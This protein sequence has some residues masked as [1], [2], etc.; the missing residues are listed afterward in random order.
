[1]VAII[2]D[3]HAHVLFHGISKV[4]L[5][6]DYET[7]LLANSNCPTLKGFEWGTTKKEVND[8]Q[9]KIAEILMI[10]QKDKRI[11]KVIMTT[12]GPSYIHDE[13]KGIFSEKSVNESFLTLYPKSFIKPSYSSFFIGY[14]N[15]IR[16]IENLPH[17]TKIFYILENP[18]LDFLP[19]EV[20]PRPYDFFNIS[21]NR[22][23]VSRTLY[24]KRMSKYRESVYNHRFSKLS[25]LDPINALC[26]N[27]KCFSQ[28]KGR[29]LYA[30]DDHFSKFGSIFIA[31][32]FQNEMFD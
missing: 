14:K 8:C 27:I 32:Y 4:A 28:I 16:K 30:D 26:D 18:E 2:G 22:D 17:V 12:R 23:T 29:F 10:I 6:N 19:K 15:T 25:V 13:V 11:E 9:K 7:V 1:M 5:K 3:S 31:N 24:L 21:V 20:I